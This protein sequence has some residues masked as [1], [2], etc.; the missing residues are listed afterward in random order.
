MAEEKEIKK[1]PKK[2][3]KYSEELQ[4]IYDRYIARGWSEER[5]RKLIDRVSA[6]KE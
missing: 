6:S 3:K 1:T 5:T 2:E 4:V